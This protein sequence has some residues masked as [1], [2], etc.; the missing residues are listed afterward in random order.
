MTLSD[1]RVI[2]QQA[3]S[4][5]NVPKIAAEVATARRVIEREIV[6]RDYLS[7]ETRRRQFVAAADRE[8]AAIYA[9]MPWYPNAK[10]PRLG[11][12]TALDYGDHRG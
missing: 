7:G 1:Y 11:F 3:K 4:A 12:F 2:Q 9:R 8:I 10:E 6:V 5:A